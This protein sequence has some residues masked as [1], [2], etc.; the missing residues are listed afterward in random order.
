MLKSRE[1]RREKICKNFCR[2]GDFRPF[3]SKN[4]QI[5]DLF[6]PLLL[7]FRIS[8]H[9]GHLTSGNG[10]KQ[11]LNGT[12]K[13]KTLNNFFCCGDF[14]SFLGKNVQIW[15]HFFPLLF[16]K[17]SESL[18]MLDIRLWEVGAKRR[19]NSTSK[20]NKWKKKIHKKTLIA[21]AILHHFWAKMLKSENTSFYFF[22]QGFR[23][24]TF[25]D[26]WLWEVGAKRCLN[27]TSKVITRTDRCTDRRTFWL[28]ESIGPGGQCF[29][30]P[31]YGRY[32]LSWLLQKKAPIPIR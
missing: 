10:S 30:N 14:R 8:K 15:D 18:K 23:I 11:H 12:S 7:G 22:P 19:L 3:L 31:A 2:F 28:I 25:L 17:D 9:F 13:K 32:Q 6:F 21:A 24:L 26:I 5:W 29:E 1:Q 4:V 20:V 16:P 27:G